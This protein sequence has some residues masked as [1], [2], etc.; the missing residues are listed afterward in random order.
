MNNNMAAAAMYQTTMAIRY[1]PGAV[2]VK[3]LE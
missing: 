1:H 3:A 2:E